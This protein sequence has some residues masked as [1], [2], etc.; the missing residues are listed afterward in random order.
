MNLLIVLLMLKLVT[1]AGSLATTA[2]L[3]GLFAFRDVLG[4]HLVALWV[5]GFA[6]I[7]LGEGGAWLLGRRAAATAERSP[8]T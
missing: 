5:G 7:A 1:L 3:V 4:P 6:A 8:E 2:G